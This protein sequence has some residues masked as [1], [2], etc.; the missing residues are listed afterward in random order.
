MSDAEYP[1][2]FSSLRSVLLGGVLLL[3]VLAGAVVARW[4][5]PRQQS[6]RH[7]PASASQ[8]RPIV[9]IVR[10]QPGLPD[11]SD[12]VDKLCPAVA[13]IVPRGTNPSDSG[14]GTPL[15]ASAYSADG[16]LVTAGSD[17]PSMPLDAIF[18]DGRRASVSDV[19][20]DAVS[21]LAIL[22]ADAVTPPLP[23]SDQTFPRVGQFGLA[24]ATPVG[25][26]CSAGTSMIASDFL[27][28]GG[29]DVGYVRLQPVPDDWSAG[30]PLLGSDGR[31]LGIGT[32]GRPGTLIP[33]PIASVII[34]ELIRN[35][36]SPSTSFGFRTV[37]YA[38]PFSSRLG[39]IRSGA[40]VALVEAGSSAERAGLRAGD[41]ITTVD[42]HPV[43]SASELSRLLDAAIGKTKLTVQRQSEQMQL[44]VKR[45][46]SS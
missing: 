12:V 45:S 7:Q 10:P 46:S 3:I 2:R 30:T 16:W 1:P 18:G 24:L 15:R 11:L 6:L 44:T 14:S 40:G 34:D 32:D 27:A 5:S 43:S 20:S 21:N 13:I 19:R 39:D 23:F 35:N 17:L 22:K 28:D 36:L 29:N 26:G 38:P 33:A 25:S 8:P 37:D 31:V 4:L 41:V 9:Q 42:D